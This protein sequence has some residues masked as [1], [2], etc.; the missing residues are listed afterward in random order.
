MEYTKSVGGDWLDADK[1]VSG[2]K[3]KL[4][5]EVVKQESKYKD[6]EGNFKTENVGKIR[7]QGADA[8][9]NIRL[10]WTSIYAMIDAYGK[11]SKEWVGKIITLKTVDAMVGDTMRTI[12]YTIPEGF[13][14]RKN[15][16]KK[17]EIARVGDAPA[18]KDD[19]VEYPSNE[20]NPDDIPF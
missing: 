3:A 5:S 9:V 2:V 11:D 7:L 14:L 18:P 10:N 15:A 8:S 6:T 16:E 12:V 13:E 20:P 1:V 19:S 4:V 17:M